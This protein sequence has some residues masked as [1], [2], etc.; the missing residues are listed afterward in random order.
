MMTTKL[1]KFTKYTALI[2]FT[3]AL[4]LGLIFLALDRETQTLS[5]ESRKLLPGSA[6]Q[7]NSNF[8]ELSN[9]QV[10]YELSGEDKSRV[11]VL[12]H[13]FSIPA[14]V[15][16]PT[17][18]HLVNE[19]YTVLRYDLYGRGFSDRPKVDYTMA[20]YVKQ[21]DELLK[22]LDIS[23]PIDLIGLSMGG[24]VATHYTNAY[25]EK[26]AKV[27]LIAPLFE[28][29]MRP[30][31]KPMLVP[32]IGEYL[33]NVIL[34]PKISKGVAKAVYDVNSFP[35][36]ETLF[37]PQTEYKGFRRAILSSIR[38]LAGKSFEVQYRAFGKL[39]K[40]V[41]LI[42]G[43]EDQTL[44]FSES[45]RVLAAIPNAHFTALEQTGHLPNYEKPDQVN[46]L[47][48]AFL[49]RQQ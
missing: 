30:E 36:W 42:W 13:G 7:N 14:Y 18:Q 43:R 15:W 47:L 39:D 6:Y 41:L 35:N 5:L 27:G 49:I 26:V 46:A 45:A 3:T 2:L 28:T 1:F 20:V 9:G 34:I 16:E 17:F 29:P 44:P 19:G 8:V 10:H 4:I 31:I 33:S 37:T 25:P 32:Y 21:L 12:V 38:N 40:P 23:E 11:V 48:S 22:A 24:A